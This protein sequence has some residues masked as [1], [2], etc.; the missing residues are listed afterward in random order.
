MNVNAD[1]VCVELADALK[2]KK[3]IFVSDVNGI[4]TEV[5]NPDSK[6]DH[7]T[8]SEI[9]KLVEKDVIYGGMEY[10]VMMA[11]EALKRGVHK[12]H[13]IDGLDSN[14]LMVEILTEKGAGTEI[15]HDE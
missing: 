1:Y 4:R 3:V 2:A 6:I 9:K 13:F 10:K 15:V 12:V 5:G 14:S 11:L 8:E 7:I